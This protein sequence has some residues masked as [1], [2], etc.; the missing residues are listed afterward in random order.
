MHRWVSYSPKVN[1]PITRH[2]HLT[3][4]KPTRPIIMQ[5]VS[6]WTPASCI[7]YLKLILRGIEWMAGT[8]A[9]RWRTGQ[10]IIVGT[11]QLMYHS[12]CS[13]IPI[14]VLLLRLRIRFRVALRRFRRENCHSILIGGVDISFRGRDSHFDFVFIFAGC[15]NNTQV[16][17]DLVVALSTPWYIAE[18][19]RVRQWADW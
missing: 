11:L 14:I 17:W 8:Y 2:S 1:N 3:M 5:K 10:Y 15:C 12:L 9:G 18:I 4:S 7:V 19:E 13:E 16:S 6:E